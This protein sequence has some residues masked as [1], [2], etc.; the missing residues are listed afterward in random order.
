[1]ITFVVFS[2]AFAIVFLVGV[3]ISF[4][5]LWS[6]SE[7]RY[8]AVMTWAT[9][10]FSV[11]GLA[12]FIGLSDSTGRQ[13][14]WTGLAAVALIALYRSSS[15]SA[16][17]RAIPGPLAALV[18]LAM[19]SIAWSTIPLT[20]AVRAALLCIV[21]LVAA[22]CT[23]TQSTASLWRHFSNGLMAVLG[24]SLL[25]AVLAPELVVD[26][27]GAFQGITSHK[28][29][30]GAT[31]AVVIVI[32]AWRCWTDSSKLFPAFSLL[33]AIAFLAWSQSAAS[34]LAIGAAGAACAMAI[35]WRTKS[36]VAIGVLIVGILGASVAAHVFLVVTGG[37]PF[38]AAMHAVLELFGKDTTL[39]GRQFLWD[40]VSEMAWQHPWLGSGYGGFWNE[41]DGPSRNVILRLNWGPP[42]QAHN[43]YLDLFN[44]LGLAGVAAFA[45][46]SVGLFIS[47]AR[48]LRSDDWKL[49]I[50]N[51]AL[52]VL[53][54]THNYAESSLL[55]GTH[56][57]WLALLMVIL[58]SAAPASSNA[59]ASVADK[60][61]RTAL[62]PAPR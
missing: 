17:L 5:L 11:V 12:S 36:H 38:V 9:A 30:L 42:T 49:G 46:M 35:I 29:T 48:Q 25:A 60:R 33:V 55:R 58:S 54:Y 18:L 59:L 16:R 14:I 31:C 56:L 4:L 32:A 20:S 39:T 57:L 13:I 43:G 61:G 3:A 28:N 45:A 27:T 8:V 7:N 40:L 15:T 22:A 19:A 2:I 24:L 62:Q 52:T 6:V 26:A 41:L 1:M 47:L 37:S 10:L 53:I 34:I 50:L 21:V 44:E 51:L 23:G